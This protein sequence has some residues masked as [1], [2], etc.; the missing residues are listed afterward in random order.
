MTIFEKLD[1]LTSRFWDV[2]DENKINTN[3]K[4]LKSLLGS[5]EFEYE[6]KRI[7]YKYSTKEK[8]EDLIIYVTSPDYVEKILYINSDPQF[9]KIDIIEDMFKEIDRMYDE[10]MKLQKEEELDRELRYNKIQ[11]EKQKEFQEWLE[12]FKKFS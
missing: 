5:K 6:N 7:R 1:F 2:S 11:E 10:Q 9:C 4:V 3:N 8:I 12:N